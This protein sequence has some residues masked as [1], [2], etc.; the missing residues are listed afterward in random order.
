[1]SDECILRIEDNEK[2]LYEV[3]MWRGR[4][5]I[6]QFEGRLASDSISMEPE[7]A[8]QIAEAILAKLGPEPA[9]GEQ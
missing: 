7:H 9:G 4:I 1:M 6:W 5:H 2:E 3:E 8:R